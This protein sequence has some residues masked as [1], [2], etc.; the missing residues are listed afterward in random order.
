MVYESHKFLQRKF[1]DMVVLIYYQCLVLPALLKFTPGKFLKKFLS[2]QNCSI[3]Q[4]HRLPDFSSCLL[5]IVMNEGVP[6]PSRQAGET[7]N[8]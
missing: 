3:F 2:S 5:Q 6:L 7:C 8:V 1:P 4:V